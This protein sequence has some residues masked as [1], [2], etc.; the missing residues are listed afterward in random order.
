MLLSCHV[1]RLKGKNRAGKGPTL[2]GP[3][4]L[5]LTSDPEGVTLTDRRFIAFRRRDVKKRLVVLELL[6]YG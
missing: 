5:I 1:D 4:L 6:P 2:R 3:A